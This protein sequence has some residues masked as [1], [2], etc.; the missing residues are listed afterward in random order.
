MASGSSLQ[1]LDLLATA[2]R[3]DLRS[4]EIVRLATE[5]LLV[6]ADSWAGLANVLEYGSAEQRAESAASLRAAVPL[7]REIVPRM[8]ES[9]QPYGAGQ[10]PGTQAAPTAAPSSSTEG[11]ASSEVGAAT[12]RRCSRCWKL[13]TSPHVCR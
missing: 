12:A 7:L 3:L 2:R 11:G 13:A 8:S 5:A 4:E 6:L 1:A 9:G 10:A